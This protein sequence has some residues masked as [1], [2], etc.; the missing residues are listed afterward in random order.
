MSIDYIK[1]SY[2]KFSQVPLF[3]YNV[4][5]YLVNNND[6][7]WKLLKYPTYD[8][9][10]KANLT[11]SEKRELIFNGEQKQTDC[12]VFLGEGQNDVWTEEQTFLRVSVVEVV[13]ENYVYGSISVGFEVYT[14]F[15][16]ETLSNYTVRQDACIQSIIETLNGAEV[17]GL[18]RLYFDS[19]INRNCRIRIIG[20][21]PYK[22]KALIM[23]NWAQ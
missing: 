20:K 1:K 2:N 11:K 9:W 19:E 17:G 18:G 13:P 21:I 4:V 14:H 8:A 10:N 3:P 5:E 6:Y 23:G 22:G 7:L 12:R 15:N 16:I